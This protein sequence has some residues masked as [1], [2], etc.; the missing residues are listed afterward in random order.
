MV[1]LNVVHDHLAEA[2]RRG[3]KKK[4]LRQGILSKVSGSRY[5]IIYLDGSRCIII[6]LDI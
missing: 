1:V 2:D 6:Y 3:S 5:I 4:Q